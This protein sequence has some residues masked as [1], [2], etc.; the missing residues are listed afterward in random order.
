MVLKCCFLRW[1]WFLFFSQLLDQRLELGKGLALPGSFSHSFGPAYLLAQFLLALIV[2]LLALI[3]V[4]TFKK[5][6]LII[7]FCCVERFQVVIK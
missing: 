1:W 5:Y 3:M 2:E 4:Q 7:G 6:T